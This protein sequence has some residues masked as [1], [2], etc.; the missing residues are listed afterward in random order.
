MVFNFSTQGLKEVHL[1]LDT[2]AD[3]SFVSKTFPDRL[4][5]DEVKS[6]LLTI[7]TSGP[8]TPMKK[9]CEI[10]SLHM[11]DHYCNLH[12]YTIAKIDAIMEP[13]QASRVSSEDKCLLIESS[14]RLSVIVNATY[15]QQ[16][17]LLRCADVFTLL[18]N[19]NGRS[20]T[21]PSG[22]RITPSKLGYLGWSNLLQTSR[23]TSLAAAKTLSFEYFSENKRLKRNQHEQSTQLRKSIKIHFNLLQSRR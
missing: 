3:R 12:N 13:I 18:D 4:Q 15:I 16:H 6:K 9:T 22:L 14:T 21:L 2:G 5:L 8:E 17:V 7:N 1:L 19:D 23:E 11:W 10:V 20:L